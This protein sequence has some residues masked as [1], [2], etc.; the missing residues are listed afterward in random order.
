MNKIVENNFFSVFP[1]ARERA[2]AGKKFREK[3]KKNAR[4]RNAKQK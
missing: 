4:N 1:G 2:V 3:N